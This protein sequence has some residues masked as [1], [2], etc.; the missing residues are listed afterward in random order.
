[1]KCLALTLLLPALPVGA[2]G[3]FTLRADLDSDGTAEQVQIAEDGI[4][5]TGGKMAGQFPRPAGVPV[6][7][8]DAPDSGI[9]FADLN[10]D[11]MADL[12]FADE[13]HEAIHLWTRQARAD[14][15]W[16]PGWSQQVRRAPRT[17]GPDHLPPLIGTTVSVKDGIL[18]IQSP[19]GGKTTLTA[20]TLIALPMPP[21]LPPEQG[22]LSLRLP[23]GFRAE[24][25]AH[26]PQITD[27]AAFEWGPDGRLWVVQMN[28]YPTG[29]DGKGQPGGVVK[30][31]TD[32]DR[33]GRYEDTTVFADELPFPTGVMPWRQGAL[34][35]AAPDIIYAVDHDGDGRAETREV[36]FTGFTPGNQQHRFNGFEW[37]L[38]G[39]IYAANGD[40]GGTVTSVKTGKTLAI[41][42][43]DVRFR[44]DTGE[45]ETVSGMTQYGLRRDDWGHWFGNNN[46]SW[47]WQVTLPEHY[48]KRNPQLAV[49]RVR[50]PLANYPDATRVFPVSPPLERP[51]QPWSL[52]HVTSACSP[53]PYRDTLFGQAFADNVFIAEPVH[54]TVH[55]EVLSRDG[56]GFRSQRAAGEE[57]RE[58]LASTDNW[59]RPV[60]LR[61]GPDG[62]LWVADYYRF[63]LEHPEWISP[64]MQARVDLRAGSDRGRLYRIAP[65]DSPRRPV[66]D[67]STMPAPALVTALNSSNGW[68]RDM[69]QRLLLERKDPAAHAPLRALLTPAHLPQ[70]RLQALAT[71]G[72]LGALDEATLSAALTDP[73]PWVRCAA[74]RESEA[75]PVGSLFP[76][77]AALARDPDPAVLLQAA[78]TLGFWPPERSEPVLA[79]LSAHPDE[80]VRVAVMSSLRPDSPLFHRLKQ[81]EVIPAAI[82]PPDLQS[83]SPDRQK[84]I[85]AYAAVE[86]LPG[87]AAAGQPLFE[88]LCALC[89]RLRG[90]GHEVGP[91][92]D[93]T[94]NK[95]TGWLLA[96]ILDPAQTVEAR[97]RGWTVTAASGPV[98]SGVI[99][100]E[101]V[102]NL[103]LRL[104]GGAEQAV[105][106]S[107]ITSM[108]PVPGSLM[109]AG[110]ESALTPQQMAD[111]LQWI[112]Q[113]K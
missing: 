21:P 27:P 24:L 104:P 73:H 74:L 12:L 110:F 60:F 9:R 81:K 80:D 72:G 62:A 4:T 98:L 19:T 101:T 17:T 20:R 108:Q 88:S 32:R 111:L 2:A 50:K 78:F 5:V 18:T 82:R 93:M 13:A 45:I 91:D 25:V 6:P 100:A 86:K 103:V 87:N 14:L 66:P 67:L 90:Q 43:R 51:N 39:W 40:S 26:E 102:N 63:V 89:H 75:F 97:Y 3:P 10:G 70:V 31:L 1:M 42:G 59:F 54:N 8:G 85:A 112:R 29:M 36:L 69:A 44:P 56:S 30:I 96:N 35:A 11:S 68:Q 52:N 83:H 106:R 47:L 28:D 22:L 77:V 92:L 64:E 46:P 33:D 65:M 53:A 58:F 99:S 38:D 37:G 71:L 105:L 95:P 94:A 109:P 48:L 55:R 34:I 16:L 84:V 57:A 61:T 49:Q 79:E 76:A 113:A 7:S 41:S 15:G 107:D 23:D